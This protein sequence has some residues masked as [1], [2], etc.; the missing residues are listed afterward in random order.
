MQYS[1]EFSNAVKAAYPNEKKLHLALDNGSDFVGRYLDDSAHWVPDPIRVV[2]MIDAGQIKELRA[3]ASLHAVAR[4]LY[5]QFGQFCS[6]W[7]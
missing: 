4:E 5:R 6:Q 2:Q 3:E 7:K 1:K